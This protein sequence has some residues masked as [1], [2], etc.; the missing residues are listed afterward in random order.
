MA[1]RIEAPAASGRLAEPTRAYAAHSG[2]ARRADD[3]PYKEIV[4]DGQR[5]FLLPAEALAPPIERA[6]TPEQ[7]RESQASSEAMRSLSEREAAIVDLVASGMV[8]K[9]IA[10]ELRI[11]EHTVSTYLRRIFAK[12]GVDTRASMVSRYQSA[13]ARR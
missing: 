12:L 9:Q 2:A 8:N 5:Y 13:K 10:M 3:P 11:S 6:P 4:L 1:S 7:V